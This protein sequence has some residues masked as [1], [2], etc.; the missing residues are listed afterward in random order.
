LCGE[1]KGMKGEDMGRG[2]MIVE[3]RNGVRR[4]GRE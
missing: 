4:G 3:K 1:L 2:E